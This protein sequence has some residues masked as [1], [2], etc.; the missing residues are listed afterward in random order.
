[1]IM[2][3]FAQSRDGL[4]IAYEVIGE[5]APALLVHGFGSSRAQNWRATGWY[6][7]LSGGGYRVIAMDCRG[8]GDSDK[9]HD[10]AL[11]GY[12]LMASDALCVL[13]AAGAARAA[14]LGYSMGGHLGIEL[15]MNHPDVVEKLV[16]AGVGENYLRA[17]FGSRFAIAEALEEPDASR[18]ADPVQKMFR[19]F[20]DQ[21]GKDRAALAACARGERKPYTAEELAQARRPVLVVCGGNDTIS[22]AAAPLAAAIPGARAVTIPGRDHMSAV[23]DKGTKEAVVEFLREI[24]HASTGSA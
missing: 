2:T 14:V 12:R 17:P 1:M 11:Y 18:I 7:A 4:R 15:L 20:A 16:L 8:H 9:P 23:G 10:P 5:G 13:E 22:G 6:G 3:A 19:S 21:P 24:P